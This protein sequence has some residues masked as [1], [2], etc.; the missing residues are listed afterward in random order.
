VH[1]ELTIGMRGSLARSFAKAAARTWR[2]ML[3]RHP[4][5]VFRVSIAGYDDDP[6][7]LCDFPEMREYV[8]RWA[9]FA[10]VNFEA[11]DALPFADEK[12]VA[13]LAACGVFGDEIEGVR[14]PPS[15]SN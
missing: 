14:E 1:I 5:A 4:K 9:R 10:W 11:L 6:R 2:E 7:E 13:F 8:C 15:K 3:K 12:T